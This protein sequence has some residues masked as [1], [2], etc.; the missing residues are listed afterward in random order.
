MGDLHLAMALRAWPV[1][2]LA[3]CL[4]YLIP[5]TLLGAILALLP[6]WWRQARTVQARP[7][8][9]GQRR[10]EFWNSMVTVL[11]F[12]MNGTLIVAGAAAGLLRLYTDPGRF[13]M[14]YL[15]ASGLLL[16]L[17]HDAWFYWTHRLMHVPGVFRRFHRTH[18]RSVAPTPWA[19]YSFAIGE[20]VVQAVFLPLMLLVLPVHPLVIFFFLLH[21]IVRNV[22]GHAGVELLPRSWLGGWWGRV[23]TTTL[24]HDMHHAHGGANYGL[25]FTWWDRRC[26]T[27]HP[28]YRTRLR[29][30]ALGARTTGAGVTPTTARTGFP[31]DP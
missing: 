8:L 1:I 6:V 12:S 23:F 22:L 14:P 21:M 30:L 15:F 20:A 3:D 26:G 16:I 11:V 29:E 24:H 13:G 4:R 25:Y 5:T 28:A 2:W 7:P 9:P 17:A 31:P 18:H 19:A 10:R 27:E